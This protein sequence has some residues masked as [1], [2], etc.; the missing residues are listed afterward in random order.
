MEALQRQ[1][2][3]DSSLGEE[4]FAAVDEEAKEWVLRAAGQPRLFHTIVRIPADVGQQASKE[5]VE[6]IEIIQ[7]R[8]FREAGQRAICAA[9]FIARNL[10]AGP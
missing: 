4:N 8:A 2:S 7:L 9:C 10:R 1:R 5:L 6:R 3:H